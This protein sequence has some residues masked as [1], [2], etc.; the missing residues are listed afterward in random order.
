VAGYYASL[1]ELEHARENPVEMARLLAANLGAGFIGMALGAP[2]FLE[3]VRGTRR[4]AARVRRT[5]RSRE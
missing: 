5:I 3:E 4:V 1:E 2:D